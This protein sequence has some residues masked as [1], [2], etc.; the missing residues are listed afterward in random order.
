MTKAVKENEAQLLSP[1]KRSIRQEPL[2]PRTSLSS[3]LVDNKLMPT[4]I[5]DIYQNQLRFIF[6]AKDILGRAKCFISFILIN[7]I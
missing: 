6:T 4:K 7:N 3:I 1:K 2:P 5:P